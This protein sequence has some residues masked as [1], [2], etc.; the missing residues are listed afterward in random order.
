MS[1]TFDAA[2]LTSAVS[3]AQPSFAFSSNDTNYFGIP[4]QFT[5]SNGVKCYT[6]DS[7]SF[8]P[9]IKHGTVTQT[10]LW[11][12]G[13][14]SL[15]CPSL[16]ISAIE[17][18]THTISY[19]AADGYTPFLVTSFIV[20]T[21]QATATK[22]APAYVTQTA[23]A[24]TLN[25][26][27]TISLPALT[28]T[29]LSTI[30]ASGETQYANTTITITQTRNQVSNLT[31]TVTHDY[32]STLFANATQTQTMY[33]NN[34]STCSAAA[35]VNLTSTTTQPGATYTVGSNTTSTAT[36]L[37]LTTSTLIHSLTSTTT[38]MTTSTELIPTT[39]STIVP[40]TSSTMIPILSNST[41][42]VS[43]LSATY[44][45]ST[46]SDV[47]TIVIGS[48]TS[49]LSGSSYGG[50][51]NS[52]ATLPSTVI[53]SGQSSLVPVA[54]PTE[55]TSVATSIAASATLSATASA[56][57]SATIIT[58]PGNDGQNYT[59]PSGDL[60]TIECYND[61]LDLAVSTGTQVTVATGDLGA[62][63][64]A[65]DSNAQCVD[66]TLS[67]VTCY[68][69]NSLEV[70]YGA[71]LVTSKSKAV[72]L[73]ST[74][75]QYRSR[76]VRKSRVNT[77]PRVHPREINAASHPKMLLGE[78]DERACPGGCT[79][80]GG[81]ASTFTAVT[82]TVTST[83]IS[84]FQATFSQTFVA[85]TLTGAV[86]VVNNVTSTAAPITSTNTF[87]ATA[88]EV[89]YQTSI[90]YTD[91]TSIHTVYQT[92]Y[93]ISTTTLANNIPCLSTSTSKTTQLTT[94]TVTLPAIA[95][96]TGATTTIPTTSVVIVS[97]T[98]ANVG[99]TATY[100]ANITIR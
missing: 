33:Q 95:F 14:Q 56:S 24:V 60:F 54:S 89:A 41:S 4:A 15:Y 81:P 83:S 64:D 1:C 34:T 12:G 65:C 73:A 29:Q 68:L 35:T 31:S 59:A 76:F 9:I 13:A 86:N 80:W 58:C 85:T 46:S 62:C 18:G 53:T 63:M 100:A 32:T 20:D 71:R 30:I 55:T 47:M 42:I 25:D 92:N 19:S 87:T 27:N 94:A 3:G 22:T 10:C 61:R 38:T 50:Y 70:S 2:C 36:S 17:T 93:A 45:V 7:V 44:H 11:A 28:T 90:V 23:N 26:T 97:S 48:T 99:L 69:K 67:G 57:A 98:T 6:D 49:T 88:T 5:S 52:S 91:V 37:V 21:A 16:K 96:T 82:T 43:Y 66:V 84:T 79:G 8:S 39:S 40:I 77:D 78:K 75:R 72:P 74:R 51:G